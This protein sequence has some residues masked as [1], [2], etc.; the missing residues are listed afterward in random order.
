MPVDTVWSRRGPSLTRDPERVANVRVTGDEVRSVASVDVLRILRR[1]AIDSTIE[2]RVGLAELLATVPPRRKIQRK[3]GEVVWTRSRGRDRLQIRH[4]RDRLKTLHHNRLLLNAELKLRTATYRAA[5][6][7]KRAE[8]KAKAAALGKVPQRR[9]APETQ[10]K[11]REATL[12]KIARARGL[13]AQ[14]VATMHAAQ[15]ERERVN[16]DPILY[17]RLLQLIAQL[18]S[19]VKGA[20]EGAATKVA[21]AYA[22]G[23]LAALKWRTGI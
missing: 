14:Y 19:R 15:R 7:L 6:A 9:S 12:L 4:L 13:K 8:R 23:K 2:T 17:E 10:R 5:Q 1:R 18:R 21:T 16:K 22:P 3:D 11:R 20:R